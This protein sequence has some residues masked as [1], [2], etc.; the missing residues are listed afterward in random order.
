MHLYYKYEYIIEHSIDWILDTAHRI[1]V[2]DAKI[3]L[4]ELEKISLSRQPQT[5]DDA[6]TLNDHFSKLMD[7]LYSIVNSTEEK[8]YNT[9]PDGELIMIE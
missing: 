7:S 9:I 4:W 3:R 2:H 6:D 8:E 1:L 5:K